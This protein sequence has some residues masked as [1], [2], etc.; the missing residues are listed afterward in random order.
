[1][2]D[3]DNSVFSFI[4]GKDSK[5]GYIKIPSFYADLEG[6]SRKGCADDVAHYILSGEPMDKAGAYGIQGKGGC[7]VREIRGSY[8]A[9]V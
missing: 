6:N 3:E 2:K 7:F 4:I 8:Y 9:A 5:V 1:M